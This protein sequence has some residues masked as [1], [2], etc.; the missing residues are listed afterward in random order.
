M[1]AFDRNLSLV[2][3]GPAEV[4]RRPLDD[5]AGVAHDEE[6]GRQHNVFAGRGIV[7]RFW[8]LF[9]FKTTTPWTDRLSEYGQLK[10]GQLEM[11]QAAH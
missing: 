3:P 1:Q 8:G 6:L 11:R 4:E 7:L 10:L 9:M 2:R 5:G